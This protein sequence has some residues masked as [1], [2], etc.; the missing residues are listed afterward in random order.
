MDVVIS[1]RTFTSSLLFVT[2]ILNTIISPKP[3][4]IDYEPRCLFY[5][6]LFFGVFVSAAVLMNIGFEIIEVVNDLPHPG[7]HYILI[8]QATIIMQM[9]F[10]SYL[11]YIKRSEFKVSLESLEK[12][13]RYLFYVG[14]LCM[15]VEKFTVDP[16]QVHLTLSFAVVLFVIPVA[17]LLIPLYRYTILVESGDIVFPATFSDKLESVYYIATFSSLAVLSDILGNALVYGILL[18]ITPLLYIHLLWLLLKE[19]KIA[20]Y[21][22]SFNGQT[23]V[24]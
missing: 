2:A 9:L 3:A 16:V 4:K 8:E 23:S 1:L 17:Y 14:A 19:I 5:Y 6:L 12:T 15:V 13:I 11:L 24:N 20:L 7:V 22:G 21:K 18:L 10:L